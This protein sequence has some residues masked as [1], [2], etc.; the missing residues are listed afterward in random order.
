MKNSTL[1]ALVA[2]C[3]CAPYEMKS[4]PVTP[5]CPAVPRVRVDQRSAGLGWAGQ[6]RAGLAGL[7]GLG[8]AGWAPPSIIRNT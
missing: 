8:W 7:A 6:G 2:C 5:S 3:S 4:G 1:K